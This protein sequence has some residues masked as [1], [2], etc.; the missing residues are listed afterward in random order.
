MGNKADVSGNDL[1]QFCV[2]DTDTDV[3]VLYLESFGNPRKFADIARLLTPEKPVVALKSGRSDPERG[4]RDRTPPRWPTPT[5]P[6]TR[7]SAPDRARSGWTRSPSC[8]TWRRYG[9]NQ[10]PPD[11]GS[12]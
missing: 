2:K 1:M 12:P 6:S 5:R 11:A 7:R 9:T 10:Y 3:V 4:A 8:S